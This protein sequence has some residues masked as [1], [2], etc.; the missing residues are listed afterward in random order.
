MSI[1]LGTSVLVAIPAVTQVANAASCSSIDRSAGWNA[2]ENAKAGAPGW[3][4]LTSTRYTGTVSGWFDKVSASCGDTVGLHLSGNGRDVTVKI[5]R[6]GYYHG[7]RARLVSTQI[8]KAV[9]AGAPAVITPA[10]VKMVYTKWPVSKLITIT[11]DYPTGIYMAKFDDGSKV[12]YAPLIIKDNLANTPIILVASTMTWQAYNTW[13]G[14]SL[15]HGPN[16]AIYDPGR[17]VSYNRPY[18]RNGESNFIHY[19]AGLVLAGE[20]AGLD[21]GYTTDNDLDVGNV[22]LARTKAIMFGGHSEYWSVGMQNAVIAARDFGINVLFFG[23][24]QAYWRARLENKGRNLA[25]W[26]IDP[27]DPYKTNPLLITD[28]WGAPPTP[29]NQSTLLGA[30]FI[31]FGLVADYKVRDGNAWPL[32]GT[33]LST[34]STIASIVGNEVD[35]TD[36]GATPGVQTFLYNNVTFKSNSHNIGFTYYN[37]DS[38]AGV[39]DASTNGWV[40]AI[41]NACTWTK[42]PVST[43]NVVKKITQNI[44]VA[45]AKGPLGVQHPAVIDISARPDLIPICD[46]DCPK[47]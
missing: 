23:G 32:V 5:Y 6:M 31:G 35:T 4:T 40:C 28:K 44:M 3:D 42:M 36:I 7:A 2:R 20:S 1:A 13:G 21:I 14:Y 17:I 9:K 38:Q 11:A 27:L 47:P 12:G 26:K 39:I 37:A 18:D 46:L 15:Y 19:E 33:G 10:P 25:S 43:S 45:S 30:L 29:G 41:D 34:G 24:N 8:V 22:S 16:T